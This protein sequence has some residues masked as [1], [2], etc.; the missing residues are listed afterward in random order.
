[1]KNSKVKEIPGFY[2]DYEK[3]RYFP[4]TN[5]H[6]KVYSEY[7][8]DKNKH[9]VESKTIE[10]KLT[11]VSGVCGVSGESKSYSPCS[12]VTLNLNKNIDNRSTNCFN[13]IDKS[14]SNTSKYIRSSSDEN[15]DNYCTNHISFFYQESCFKL[16]SNKKFNTDIV[17]NLKFFKNL[18]SHSDLHRIWLKDVKI[19]YRDNKYESVFFEDKKFIFTLDNCA[20]DQHSRIY[21]DIVDLKKSNNNTNNSSYGSYT[22]N[23]YETSQIR[24]IK[25]KYKDKKFNSF[26]IIQNLLVLVCKFE[27]FV[28]FIDELFTLDTQSIFFYYYNFSN[29]IPNKENIPLNLDIPDVRIIQRENGITKL[30]FLYYKSKSCFDF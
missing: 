5:A 15:F 9:V 27:V 10:E 14:S 20:L 18:S 16:L 22:P 24:E 26:K 25:L 2:F 1:M 28:L 7:M 11:S 29:D 17:A 3:N 6:N 21:I 30:A 23:S 4:I 12:T 19:K 8:K 13:Y